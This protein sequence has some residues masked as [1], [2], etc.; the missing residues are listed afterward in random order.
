MN[1]Y[2]YVG[3]SN[4]LQC[5]IKLKK[6]K[7]KTKKN[8]KNYILPLTFIKSENLNEVTGSYFDIVTAK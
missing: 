4:K 3:K 8:K 6:T 2:M 7:T 1:V 5:I